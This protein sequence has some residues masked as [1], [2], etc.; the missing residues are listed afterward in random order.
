M[1]VYEKKMLQAASE[2]W[3]RIFFYS[4]WHRLVFGVCHTEISSYHFAGDVPYRGRNLYFGKEVKERS[5]TMK[6]VVVKAPRFLRGILKS[7]FKIRNDE[8]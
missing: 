5:R 8:T 2:L 4:C 7:I 6:I 1:N 3:Y